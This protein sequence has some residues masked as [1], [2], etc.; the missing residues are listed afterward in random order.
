[1]DYASQTQSQTQTTRNNEIAIKMP[2]AS[3]IGLNRALLTRGEIIQI[4]GETLKDY[5]MT[6]RVEG[7]V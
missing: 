1:M 4:L 7:R 6:E 2:R 3:R 5:S